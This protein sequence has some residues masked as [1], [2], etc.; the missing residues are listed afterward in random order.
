MSVPSQWRT[1]KQRY[2]LQGGVCPKCSNVVFPPRGVC[3]YCSREHEVVSHDF[4]LSHRRNG[5]AA[6]QVTFAM[7]EAPERL[8]MVAAGD[9]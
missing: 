8:A 9:D 7:P 3:P 1:K 5:N 4:I 2:S 6:R